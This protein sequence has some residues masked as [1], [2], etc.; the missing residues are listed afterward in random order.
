MTQSALQAW[1]IADLRVKQVQ[2][3]SNPCNYIYPNGV[4]CHRPILCDHPTKCFMRMLIAPVLHV[5]DT[6]RVTRPSLASLPGLRCR[7][8]GAS[9][10]VRVEQRGIHA[11][12]FL[13]Y[14]SKCD[15][16]LYD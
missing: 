4:Q 12:S 16:W 1:T 14:C 6:R 3:A 10:K 15:D 2:V 7:D 11:G 8:S 13:S 9:T 5:T